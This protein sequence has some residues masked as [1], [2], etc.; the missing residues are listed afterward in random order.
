MKIIKE[1]RKIKENGLNIMN[2][3]CDKCGAILE[4]TAS[5]LKN[6]ST[7]NIF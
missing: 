6:I 4:I 5:D 7:T 2:I 3:T 1:G